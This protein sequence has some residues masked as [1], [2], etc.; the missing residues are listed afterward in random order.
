MELSSSKIEKFLTFQE[1]E[2]FSPKINK[3]LIFSQKTFFL[4]FRKWSCLKKT[5]YISGR[6]LRAAKIKK[7]PSEKT[8]CIFSKESFSYISGNGPRKISVYFRKQNFLIY[9]ETETLK[10]FLYFRK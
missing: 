1:M 3:V 9:Q 7:N 8:D 10:N 6:N 4:C 5:S 2:L